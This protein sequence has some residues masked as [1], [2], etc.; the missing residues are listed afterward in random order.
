MP[1]ACVPVHTCQYDDTGEMHGSLP[2]SDN[3]ENKQS[4]KKI[5]TASPSRAAC[6]QTSRVTPRIV[7][8]HD[9]DNNVEAWKEGVII[10][11]SVRA[12]PQSIYANSEHIHMRTMPLSQ[13]DLPSRTT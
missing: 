11:N 8:E 12:E 5:N 4:I 3:Y 10:S 2:S 9:P 13:F 7:P 1:K 6:E